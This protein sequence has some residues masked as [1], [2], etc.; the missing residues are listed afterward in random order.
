MR[1]DWYRLI[2]I[3]FSLKNRTK[4]NFCF[5]FVVIDVYLYG[6]FHKK[7]SWQN[8]RIFLFLPVG[9]GLCLCHYCIL[10]ALVCLSRFYGTCK[11]KQIDCLMGMN[12]LT[13][14]IW[15]ESGLW[16]IVGVFG[17]TFFVCWIFE[18]DTYEHLN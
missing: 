7:T 2:L 3:F 15:I 8:K 10:V 5:V 4:M 9:L 12:N 14:F 1:L 16:F 11:R 18:I 13:E 6:I 17:N